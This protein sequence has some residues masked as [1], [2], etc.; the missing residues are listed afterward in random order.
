M[1]D[2]YGHTT[3]LDAPV[4]DGEAVADI[5]SRY[6]LGYG[7]LADGMELSGGIT[8]ESGRDWLG[9]SGEDFFVAFRADEEIS[10]SE[11]DVTD[12]LLREIQPYLEGKLVIQSIGSVRNRFP[13]S[14]QEIIVPPKEGEIEINGFKAHGEE[15]RD[16]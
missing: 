13:F 1:A 12:Q 4:S 5:L 10:D 15:A 8:E 16:A 9:F 2:F 6:R 11:D 14:A 7:T 3:S